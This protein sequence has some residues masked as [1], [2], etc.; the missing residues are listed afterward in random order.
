MIRINGELIDPDLLQ[1]A[2]ARIKSEAEARLQVSCC[3][4][5]PEFMEQAEEEVIDSVL[6]AQEAETRYPKIPADK[7]KVSI[8]VYVPKSDRMSVGV[9]KRLNRRAE[10]PR[11]IVQVYIV[12]RARGRLAVDVSANDVEVSI[13][14]DVSKGDGIGVAAGPKRRTLAEGS[15]TIVQPD[16]VRLPADP[17]ANDIEVTVAIKVPEG[18]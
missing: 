18:D 9:P 17:P 15:R 6:I 1:D 7:I 2:F 13:A 11:S 8:A 4:R 12:L 16:Q 3:E 10:G 14:V 5:D